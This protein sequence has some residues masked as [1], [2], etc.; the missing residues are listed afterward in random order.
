MVY[1]DDVIFLSWTSHGLQHVI[2]GMHQFCLSTFPMMKRQFDAVVKLTVLYGYEVWVSLCFE[3]LQPGLK[4]WIGLQIAYFHLRLKLRR[5]IS[6][7]V[8][9]AELAEVQ[10]Q[11]SWWSQVLCFMK[12]LNCV[13]EGSLHPVTTSVID[14]IHHTHDALGNPVVAVFTMFM[15]LLFA[16]LSKVLS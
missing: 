2:D 10:W 5:G 1:A 12:K 4:G 13:A 6:P 15:T 16:R 3:N 14:N 9:F 8:L 11:R 7:H